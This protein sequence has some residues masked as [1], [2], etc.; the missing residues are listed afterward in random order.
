M[1]IVELLHLFIN[2]SNK[3]RDLYD[4]YA[5]SKIILMKQ[6]IL[7]IIIMFNNF[8][9]ICPEMLQFL[10]RVKYPT[11]DQMALVEIHTFDSIMEVY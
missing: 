11:I 2:P 4:Q 7:Y 6:P 1:L 5:S 8:I 10:Q 9:E 3:N